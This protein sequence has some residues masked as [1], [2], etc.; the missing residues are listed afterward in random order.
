MYLDFAWAT[1]RQTG[2]TESHLESRLAALAD[3]EAGLVLG[4]DPE[5]RFHSGVPEEVAG[6]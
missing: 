4:A 6:A 5:F 3:V 2:L 1:Q